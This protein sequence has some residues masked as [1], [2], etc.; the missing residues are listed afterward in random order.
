L[1]SCPGI[2]HL[3]RQGDELPPFDF[4]IPLLSL[5]H[6]LG[7]HLGNI[8]AQVPYLF[9]R[10]DLICRWQERLRDNTGFK[11]GICWQGS[12][13]FDDDRDR[14]FAVT[15]FAAVADIP[16]VR[17]ISLQKGVNAE[18]LADLRF[19]V[20]T[21]GAG[22]DE[23]YG[24]FMDSAAVMHNLDLVITADTAIAH[25]AGAMA[26]PVW[27]ALPMVADWRWLMNRTDSPW[28]PTMRLIRQDKAG[29]WIGVFQRIAISLRQRLNS[30][31]PFLP[32][33]LD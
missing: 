12:T 3:V 7:T 20:K 25:L 19:A 18:Q 5:P 14:S 16:G 11:I 2:D 29:D 15:N 4:H 10:D 21:L 30:E 26:V 13:A 24:A 27:V 23:G 1:S 33:K 9:A 31:I 8:P 22:F 28:Y 32:M 6:R 17:L